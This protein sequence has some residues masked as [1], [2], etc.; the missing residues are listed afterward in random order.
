MALRSHVWKT[1]IEVFREEGGIHGDGIHGFQD[2]HMISEPSG[3][4]CSA[5]KVDRS[6]N[7]HGSGSTPIHELGAVQISI[8]RVSTTLLPASYRKPTLIS[9]RSMHA[10]CS[11]PGVLV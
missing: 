2:I 6:L 1:G 5:T 11:V 10:R 3:E 7:A 4:L 9:R 8:M